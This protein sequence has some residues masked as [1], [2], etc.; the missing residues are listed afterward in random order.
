MA[1]GGRLALAASLF[2]PCALVSLLVCDR[3]DALISSDTLFPVELVWDV[4]HRAGA[5]SSFQQPR[6]PSLVPD[7]LIFGAT[8]V[9][10]GSWRVAMGLW[11]LGSVCGLAAV[12]AWITT[13]IARATAETATLAAVLLVVLVLAAAAL[14]VF[15]FAPVRGSDAYASPCLFVLLP[16]TDGGPFLLT[17]VAAAIAQ[18]ATRQPGPGKTLGLA[19]LCSAACAADLLS[20]V[21]LLLPP[22]A[23]LLAGL[24]VGTVARG[25]AIR[26]LAAAL[27]GGAVGWLGVQLLHREPRPRATLHGI[28]QAVR[29]IPGELIHQHSM[30]FVMLIVGAGLV[31]LA[32]HASVRRG[33]RFWLASFWPVFAATGVLGSLAVML[34]LYSNLW[35]YRYALSFLWWPVI[36]A[37]V[38]LA[39]FFARHRLSLRLP[40][41]AA[42][43]V[44]AVICLVSVWHKPRLLD[45]TSPLASCLQAAGLQTGL[46]GYWYARRTS[47]ASDWQLQVEPLDW[48]GAAYAWGNDPL[49]FTHDLHDGSRR[50][51]YRFVI[52]DELPPERIAA[53]YGAPD[54]V[55]LCGATPVW[56]YNGRGRPYRELAR[57]SP[58]L[59]DIFAVA[60]AH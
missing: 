30:M 8:Q 54:R 36:V 19:L 58:A 4:L 25:T 33:M 15:R 34:L 57:A 45:W 22:A 41:A 3:P 39:E 35:S 1:S 21:S 9:A 48:Q 10:T 38:A 26:L 20:F 2:V 55:L 44:L 56:V 16:F 52:P 23:A 42:T 60:P 29:Q 14:G 31:L 17:L 53:I 50:P 47:A 7:L 13:R 40:M 43:V 37:A 24:W 12:A 6:V 49:W 27:G 46:A 5:W 32:R 59:A 18:R 11:V 28:A 51:D